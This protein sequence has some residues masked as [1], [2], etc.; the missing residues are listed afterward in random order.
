MTSL[1][2]CIDFNHGMLNV[3]VT[4]I[5]R[6]CSEQQAKAS[7]RGNCDLSPF[8]HPDGTFCAPK[9]TARLVP[10]SLLAP[11]ATKACAAVAL[12]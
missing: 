4:C 9:I 2:E 8:V 7:C 1:V 5:V 11:C 3:D 12:S 10:L 6:R